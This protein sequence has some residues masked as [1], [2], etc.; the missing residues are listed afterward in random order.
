MER[1]GE[2]ESLLGTLLKLE[3]KDGWGNKGN[4]EM[5]IIISHFPFLLFVNYFIVIGYYQLL[6]STT[7]YYHFIHNSIDWIELNPSKHRLL[8]LR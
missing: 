3:E 2:P 6:P 7:I 8:K 1:G 5:R 4:E